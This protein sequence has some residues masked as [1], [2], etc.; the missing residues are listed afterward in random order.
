MEGG[1]WCNARGGISVSLLSVSFLEVSVGVIDREG[2]SI[3]PFYMEWKHFLN[4]NI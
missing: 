1:S 2:D 3:E 4:P